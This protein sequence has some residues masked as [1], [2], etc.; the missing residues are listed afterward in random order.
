MHVMAPPKL[1]EYCTLLLGIFLITLTVTAEK[2]SQKKDLNAKN[3]F[4]DEVSKTSE[5][6]LHIIVSNESP[7]ERFEDHVQI[8]TTTKNEN[9][10]SAAAEQ[11]KPPIPIESGKTIP[12]IAHYEHVVEETKVNTKDINFDYEDDDL[13]ASYITGFYIFLALSLSAMLFIVFRVYRL[14]LSR[15]E[16]KYGVQGDRSTQELV[17]LP[18]SIEDGNSEDEDHTLFDIGRQQARRL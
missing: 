5:A 6:D 14:R 1:M 10:Y 18:V 7:K 3:V 15:A 16:R 2:Q 17:P 12:P 4:A 9:Q 13:P 8:S 11:Q